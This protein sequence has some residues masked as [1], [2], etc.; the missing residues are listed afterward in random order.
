MQHQLNAYDYVNHPYAAVREVLLGD[1][2]GTFE[3][4]TTVAASRAEEIGAE[5]RANIGSLVVSATIQIELVSI[6]T[7]IGPGAT[8]ATNFVLRWRAAEHPAL[9]PAMDA[10]L[11]IYALTPTETQLDLCGNYA[12]PLG[13]LGQAL[14][15]IALHHIAKESV[16]GFIQ[17][18]AKFLRGQLSERAALGAAGGVHV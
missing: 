8:P 17:S 16:A 12:P 18:V 1:A 14:D 3:R 2:L 9:F 7:A 4:A 11:S 15:S 13:V 6:E 5:L 10:V